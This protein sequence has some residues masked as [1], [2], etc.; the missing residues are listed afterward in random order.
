MYVEGGNIKKSFRKIHKTIK[1]TI[2]ISFRKIRK[3]NTNKLSG[4]NYKLKLQS[5]FPEN[6]NSNFITALSGK[7]WKIQPNLHL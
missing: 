7:Y 1:I 5:N 6:I 2:H 4:K 3:Y